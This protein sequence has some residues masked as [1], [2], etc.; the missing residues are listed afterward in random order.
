MGT[1]KNNAKHHEEDEAV[2]DKYFILKPETGKFI[3]HNAKQDKLETSNM[4]GLF[5][6]HLLALCTRC[7]GKR[8]EISLISLN[9]ILKVC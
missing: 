1:T 2:S 9:A 8:T 3:L 5:F 7:Q 6:Q 4:K